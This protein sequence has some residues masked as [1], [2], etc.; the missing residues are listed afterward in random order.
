[1]L[2]K[3]MTDGIF[4]IVS[5]KEVYMMQKLFVVILAAAVSLP[6]FAKF[7]P[8]RA[9]VARRCAAESIVLLKND[10]V[11]PLAKGA[12]VAAVEPVGLAWMGCGRGSAWIYMPYMIDIAQG[13]TN[14]GFRVD[15]E[16]RD[17]AVWPIVRNSTEGR[18]CQSLDDYYLSAAE[19]AKLAELKAAGF[20][21]IVVVLNVGTIISLAP[22]KDDPAVSAILYVSY[23]GMEGGNAVADVISGAVNPS[24]RLSVTFA[25][26]LEDYPSDATWQEGR[27]YVPYEEDIFV[28]YRYFATIPGACGKVTYPFGYGLSY[29]S[30]ALSGKSVTR[31]DGKVTVAVTVTN[32]GKAP[33]RNAVLAYV[34]LKGGKAQH[35]AKELKAFAK[36]K[37]LAPGE[38]EKLSMTFAEEDLAYFDDE[39]VSGKIGS[40]AIDGGTYTVFVGGEPCCAEEAGSFELPAR[41]LSTP[42]FKLEPSRLARRLRADGTFAEAPVLYGDR[43]GARVDVPE[44]TERP[45]PERLIRLQQVAKGEK[46][47]DEF[48]DQMP[49]ADMMQLMVGQDNILSVG[50]TRSIGVLEAYGVPGLQTADGPVGIR[51][52]QQPKEGEKP[53]ED[54]LATAFPATALTSCSFDPAL[55][56]EY[57]RV[58][59]AE[60]VEF[61]IDIHL[62]PGICLARHPM[63][64]RNFEYMGE[65]P[66][67]AGKMA[68]AYIR[69]VQSQGVGSTIKHFAAN[70]R[71]NTR[72]ESYDI[73]SE[74]AM[75]EVYLRGF[76]IAVKEAKPKCV[77]T[78]Y[79]GIN[80]IWCGANFGLIEGILRGEWGFEGLVM[81]DWSARSHLWQN[82]AAGND[83]KMPISMPG[84]FTADDAV[85]KEFCMFARQGRIDIRRI[86]ASAK[87]VLRLV[88][89]S[90]RFR[91]TLK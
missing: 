3:S 26:R 33:G 88:M 48:L 58:L 82:I 47:L 42:G 4:R 67:L 22:L 7:S 23:P 40:W 89:D 85:V 91:A 57:G 80:G 36:T 71:E 31:A 59:G 6:V 78:A 77:M 63:C 70:N 61:S 9:E 12:S 18:E 21:K 14:A 5:D 19:L 81:T 10:G 52:G 49:F 38:S 25:N 11:L 43:N 56:E 76:E 35:P 28:G 65:D 69:G 51:L 72:R 17:V 30:F 1:M 24:G 90:P 75:R 84:D 64:G 39:G 83:V 54:Q 15:A 73:V 13:L 32:K 74:R 79:N 86:R 34:S 29:T 46:T 66:Y 41:I 20:K 8:E 16:S 2:I 45:S 50:N 44:V 68:A 87:R 60:A 27:H 62:A 37:L 55:Q 53:T